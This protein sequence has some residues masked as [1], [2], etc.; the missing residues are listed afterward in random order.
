MGLNYSKNLETPKPCYHNLIRKTV[1]TC[2]DCIGKG[3]YDLGLGDVACSTC[4]GLKFISNGYTI[5][6]KECNTCDM[7]G[8]INNFNCYDCYGA[9]YTN[10]CDSSNCSGYTELSSEPTSGPVKSF[11]YNYG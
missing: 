1:D 10:I 6:G 9:K 8:K 2:I 3:Y 5:R 11:I 4:N 7:T